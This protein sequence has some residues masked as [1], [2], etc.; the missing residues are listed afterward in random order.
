MK[1]TARRKAARQ[2]FSVPVLLAVALLAFAGGMAA[3]NGTSGRDLTG[4]EN[5]SAQI[6]GQ[7]ESAALPAPA[8]TPIPASDKPFSAGGDWALMLVNWRHSLPESCLPKISHSCFVCCFN[9]GPG[10]GRA[11]LHS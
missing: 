2:R 6:P 11:C 3:G 5:L 7:M 1:R 10:V 4:R 9:P 8:P